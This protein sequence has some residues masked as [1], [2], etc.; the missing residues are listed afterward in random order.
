[1]QARLGAIFMRVLALGLLLAV[2]WSSLADACAVGHGE[3]FDKAESV[4][5]MSVESGRSC[6]IP[7]F[8][9]DTATLTSVRIAKQAGNGFADIQD[10]SSLRYRSRPGFKGRDEFIVALCATVHGGKGC[11][12]VRVNVTVY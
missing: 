10:G 8:A 5:T 1:L 7:T 2:T 11:A 9:N 3:L 6:S 12:T 4:T